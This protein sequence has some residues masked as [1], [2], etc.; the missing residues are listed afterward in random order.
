M[1]LLYDVQ[2]NMCYLC[3]LMLDYSAGANVLYHIPQN[4]VLN[5]SYFMDL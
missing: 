3:I 1:F 5:L 2:L 4:L